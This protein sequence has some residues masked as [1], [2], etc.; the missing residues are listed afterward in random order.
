M[1]RD[2]LS[3]DGMHRFAHE[4][5]ACTFEIVICDQELEYARQASAAAFTEIDRLEQ[6]LSRFISHSD[7]SRVNALQP[8]EW[9]R[10]GPAALDCLLLAG[11]VHRDTAG[12]FDITVGGLLH[13][14]VDGEAPVVGM[15]M[16]EVSRAYQ[17]AGLRA[18]RVSID[19]GA[20]GKGYAVD[21]AAKLLEEWGIGRAIIH[22][23]QSTALAVGDSPWPLAV[24][25]P[26]D[27]DAILFRV[28]LPG[29][30]ALSG[31]GIKLHGNH[32]I[33]PRTQ[34]PAVARLGAWAVA[35]TAALSDAV[36]TA[37][38][39]MTATEME[40]YC[41]AHADVGGLVVPRDE[42]GPFRTF[43]TWEKT[44]TPSAPPSR[45]SGPE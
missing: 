11:E 34:Q 41:A 28:F 29:G 16:L 14:A 22:S 44:L 32:I 30:W 26:E 40:Q 43:G 20:I 38:M 7:V 17:A 5:M 24:R 12:A 10:L 23:G 31:S 27:H 13:R 37:F 4:A 6:E 8:G 45:G 15:Q 2:V 39:V 21:Q 42:V 36:S 25:D 33:D 35:P 9:A 3:Q 18:G 1:I 19:L